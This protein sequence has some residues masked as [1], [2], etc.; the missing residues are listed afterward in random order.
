[1]GDAENNLYVPF[2]I[3]YVPQNGNQPVNGLIPLD[4]RVTPCSEALDVSVD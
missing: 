1:M 2:Q 4:P 3:N